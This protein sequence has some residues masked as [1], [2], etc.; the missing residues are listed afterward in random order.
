MVLLNVKKK[1]LD[2]LRCFLA[3]FHKLFFYQRHRKFRWF[4]LELWIRPGSCATADWLD[5]PQ[6]LAGLLVGETH[7][8]TLPPHRPKSSSTRS[9]QG[10][11]PVSGHQSEWTNTGS[12]FSNNPARARWHNRGTQE[13]PCKDVHYETSR[14]PCR[15]EASSETCSIY[16]RLSLLYFLFPLISTSLGSHVTPPH[17]N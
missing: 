11:T 6:G 1:I 2:A 7:T 15:A 12:G 17:Q 9:W 14:V 16:A 4:H 5:L 13:V 8:A 3:L 10:E